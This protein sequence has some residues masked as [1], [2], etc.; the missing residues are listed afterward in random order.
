M[1]KCLVVVES[2]AKARTISK[3]LGSNYVVRASNGHVRDLPKNSLG[4]DIENGFA[5]K[6]LPLP[7]SAAAI[8]HI[9][10]AAKK[11]DRI[12]LASDPDREGEAIGWHVAQLL[13]RSGKPIQRIEFNAITKRNVTEAVKHPRDI[14]QDLVD[15]QQARRIL[16]RLVGYKISPL[17]QWRVR[18]G[19]SAGRVQS[20]AVRMVCDREAEIRSFV[21][22]EYWTI[23][24]VL[25]TVH[26]EMMTARLAM[27]RGE[28]ARVVNEAGARAIVADLENAEYRVASVERK[29]V[30][31]HP[32]APFITSTLQQEAARKL[33]FSPRQTMRIAQVL[34][35]GVTVG[36]EGQVGI[37]T[38]MRTDSTR[39]DP[40]AI[41]EVR[42]YIGRNFEPTMLPESPNVYRSKRGAQDAHEAI[43]PTSAF[44][45]PDSLAAYLDADQLKLY[46]L[47]WQRFVASQMA[48][49][50]LDQ[51]TVDVAAKEY[52]F[53]ATGSV[54]KFA[55]F[56]K[57]Y[58]ESAD[59]STKNGRDAEADRSIPAVAE[60]ER[61]SVQELRPE[62]HF[63]KPPPRYSEASLIRALEENGIGRPS[64]Y[65][66]TINTI[67][68]RG[69]VTRE[70][71]YLRPTELGEQ[72]NA[73]LLESFPDILDIN[74]TASLEEDLDHVEEGR[75]SWSE[76]LAAFYS[77]FS[78]NLRTAQQ[79]MVGE[80]AEGDAP[81]PECGKPME[82]RTGRFGPFLACTDY[83]TCRGSKRIAKPKTVEETGETCD[84]C[85][86]PM[87]IREGRF[88][89]FMA[90]SKYPECKN[91]YNI[92]ESGNKIPKQPKEPPKKTQQKCPQC[93]GFL[94][95]RKS[96]AGEEFYGCEHY[97]KC[98][99]TKPMELGLKCLRPGCDGNLVTRRGKG[100]RFIGC[101]KYP[102][103]DY[104]VFG[105]LDKETPCP[106]CGNAWTVIAKERN[107]SRRR[108]CPVP[109]CPFEEAL[110]E[111]E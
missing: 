34:Y 84:Q 6:Y 108:K 102:T 58:E 52:V 95:I 105:Q 33:R 31:R 47:I 14:D 72:V 62:Q 15:A 98:R 68:D 79:R 13:K 37:I 43:R 17:L 7:D 96:R 109:G 104:T 73:L 24:A 21:P 57:L 71:A 1:G 11:V 81:C 29:E 94:L 97:P 106:T 101:D 91:T 40:E 5:P 67:Q 54:V 99:F 76:L 4:V 89:R 3:L 103:C 80:Q 100:R 46:T 78:R 111:E 83:P 12:L 87:V 50:V 70:K 107:K 53:R 48:S 16:D 45:T 75:R 64:T 41:A 25:K 8:K 93:D 22:E 23:D 28:K 56:T 66:P 30:R 9:R 27:I 20:V 49:A 65:A 51:T 61:L 55:G 10:E 35:E 110:P 69:Y 18:R 90:C 36:D 85:G 74:F 2:P 82:L 86:A 39:I 59:D 63:T 42:D 38:Y 92:D 60:G 19:L 32:Y 88:G 77:G 26:E 44:R